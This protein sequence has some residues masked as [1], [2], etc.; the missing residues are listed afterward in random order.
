MAVDGT[1]N[2]DIDTPMGK[3]SGKL[4]LAAEGDSLSGSFSGPQGEQSFSG[5]TASGDSASWSISVNSPMG[6]MTLDFTGAVDGDKI[7]GQVKLGSFGT[8]PFS[9]SRA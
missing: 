6:Q 7:S 8:A 4:V 5:G 2:V 9:G 3:Q 1:Y